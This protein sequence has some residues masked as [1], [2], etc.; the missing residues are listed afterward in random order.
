[1]AMAM[2]GEAMKLVVS[3][4]VV[5]REEKQIAGRQMGLQKCV[6]PRDRWS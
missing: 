6:C 1:M 5:R 2:A 3:H 4:A